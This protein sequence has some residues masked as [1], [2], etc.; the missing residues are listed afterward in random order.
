[1]AMSSHATRWL[2]TFIAAPILLW[3][4]LAAP[5]VFL[6]MVVALAG[7]AAW[8]EYFHICFKPGQPGLLAVV[9]GGW[10]VVV[11]GAIHFGW[12]GQVAGLAGAAAVGLVYF[13]LNYT[14][15]PSIIDQTGRFALGHIYVSLF[16]SLLIG[17]FALENG[18]RWILFA[19]LVTFIGDTGAYYVGRTWGRRPLYPAVSPNKTW[20][21]LGGNVLACTIT[22]AVY[23]GLLLPT[24]WYEAA[25]LGMFLGIW[26]PAGDLFESMLKRAAGVKDSGRILLGHGGILDRIDALLFNVPVIYFF[27]VVR[28]L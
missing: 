2:V 17:L 7:L 10:A 19:L 27:A 5:P 12:P 6:H 23:A 1:M 3:V 18:P 25:G 13:L 8:W 20:E 14:R 26:G 15:V 11:L 28:G 16:L 9:L 24:P 4:I 22:A 21:G